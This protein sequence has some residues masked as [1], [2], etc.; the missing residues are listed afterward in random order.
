MTKRARGKESRDVGR[1]TASG[2]SKP[3]NAGLLPSIPDARAGVH[4]LRGRLQRRAQ[5]TQPQKHLYSLLFDLN[6]LTLSWHLVGGKKGARIAGVDRQ[7][8]KYIRN[9]IGDEAFVLGVQQELKDET[10]EPL[11][12][13]WIKPGNRDLAIRSV[14]DRVVEQAVLLILNPIFDP[15]FHPH[16]FAYR[17]GSG[18]RQANDLFK[19]RADE[20]RGFVRTD[21]SKCFQEVRHKVVIGQVRKRVTDRRLLALVKDLL[22]AGATTPGKGIA[23]G[24]ILGPFLSNVVLDYVDQAFPRGRGHLDFSYL[25]TCLP[26]NSPTNPVRPPVGKLAGRLTGLALLYARYADDIVV[27]HNGESQA[28]AD[29]IRHLLR[30]L[31]RPLGLKMH[32]A[33]TT[34]GSLLDGFE[35]CNL[36]I[37][38]K[39]R[40]EVHITVPDRV[41]AT[42]LDN[43]DQLDDDDDDDCYWNY[44]SP[45]IESC[46]QRGAAVDDVARRI[47]RMEASRRAANRSVHRNF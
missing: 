8:V 24:T 37:R 27:L 6:L 31:L 18:N 2:E 39:V 30:E 36:D 12:V 17:A 15:Y 14:K 13:R 21:V 40:A 45:R 26:S 38:V 16:S 42:W 41:I 46:A 29:A 28:Q 35:F 32:P 7:T 25:A 22:E 1:T 9:H 3:V 33:K 10:Y 5:G 47:R 23:M 20:F 34:H 44:L 43:L 4:G 19:R 11:P